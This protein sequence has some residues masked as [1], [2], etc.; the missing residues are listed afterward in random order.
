MFHVL[1]RAVARERIFWK[2]ADYE[3]F[4]NVSQEAL[5]RPKLIRLRV[6]AKI[7]CIVRFRV[8]FQVNSEKLSPAS[9]TRP[10]GFEAVLRAVGKP[11]AIPR[12]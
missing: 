9:R 1:N 7:R 12:L 2:P 4:E 6:N 10:V 3:A 5:L 8:G 11:S